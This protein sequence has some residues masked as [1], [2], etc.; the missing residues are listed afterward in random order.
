MDPETHEADSPPSRA[1]RDLTT[2]SIPRHLVAFSLPMLAGSALQ[3]AYGFVNAFWVGR[4]L[5]AKALAAVTVSQPVI[6]VTIAAAAGM[7]LAA[8]INVPARVLTPSAL[9]VH[10]AILAATDHTEDARAEK[11]QIPFDKLLPQ[12]RALIEPG[13]KS[14]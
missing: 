14:E 5:G 9:A 11:A 4:F 12:E 6:F 10:A 2:G 7:T 1:G 3:T 13:I 8:K